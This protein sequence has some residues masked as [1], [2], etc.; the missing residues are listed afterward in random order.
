MNK[1][2]I[3]AIYPLAPMQQSML[4]HTLAAT[5][6]RLYFQQLSC[7]LRGEL[8][9]AAFKAAWQCV[10][11][12]HDVLRTLFT[13]QNRNS[14]LQVVLT[15]TVLPWQELDWRALDRSQQTG[16]FQNFMVQ[17]RCRGFQLDQAP[18]L[19]CTLIRVSD[20]GYRFVFSY[21]HIL[22]DAW[23]FTIVL[24]EVFACYSAHIQGESLNLAPPPS[25]R[26]YL[27]WLQRQ[28]P[29]QAEVY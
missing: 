11:E 22:M 19:R 29:A 28:D 1:A 5:E 10:V 2:D 27:H 3:E 12:R 25:Y 21:H 17:D 20:R 13:G 8:E 7:S 23:A 14:P 16:R 6:S 26:D 18:L 24:Q 9:M 4:L 15:K